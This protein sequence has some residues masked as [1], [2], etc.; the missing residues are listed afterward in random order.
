[1]TGSPLLDLLSRI[2]RG[3]VVVFDLDATLLWSGPRHLRIAQEF[4]SLRPAADRFV[5]QLGAEDFG[6]DATAT[7]RSKGLHNAKLL[8]EFGRFWG[9][10]YFT[11]KYALLDQPQPG[12]VEFVHA[13][14]QKGAR[15]VYLTGR[16]EPKMGDGTRRSLAMHAFP[17]GMRAKLLLKPVTD[18]KDHEWKRK[19]LPRL[20]KLGRVVATFENEPGNANLFAD[21]FPD[22]THFLMKTVCSPDAAAP[23]PDL[24][25]ISDFVA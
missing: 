21:A 25:P 6:Y 17:L 3:D 18:M 19:A 13:C 24:V 8:R 22:A 5:R 11:S 15:I 9:Q 4:A 12:A 16:D 2:T 7:L 20:E 14:S 23:K 10:H 1:M